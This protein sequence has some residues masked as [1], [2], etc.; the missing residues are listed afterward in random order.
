MG[1]TPE[2]LY[3]S[4][5]GFHFEFSTESDAKGFYAQ[6]KEKG[7]RVEIRGKTVTVKFG[8]ASCDTLPNI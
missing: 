1:F 3:H 8:K 7:S 4:E 5:E 6:G 2:A